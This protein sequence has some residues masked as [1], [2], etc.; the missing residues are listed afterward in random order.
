MP[1]Y[2]D[3]QREILDTVRERFLAVMNRLIEDGAV[4]DEKNF[5]LNIKM[6][7]GQMTDIRSGKRFVTVQMIWMMIMKYNV[8]ANYLFP[9]FSKQMFLKENK[10]GQ[11]KQLRIEIEQKKKEIKLLE[12]FAN[13]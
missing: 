4:Q 3:T 13:G 9:P 1:A 8:N 10:K 2:P 11:I 7:R 12:E 6:R 5:L